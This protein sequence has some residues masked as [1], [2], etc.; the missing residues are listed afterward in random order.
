[1]EIKDFTRINPL[2]IT[3]H[4]S[5]IPLSILSYLMAIVTS[6]RRRTVRICSERGGRSDARVWAFRRNYVAKLHG[7][8][9]PRALIATSFT[10]WEIKRDQWK[11]SILGRWES[12][13]LTITST[14]IFSNGLI[15]FEGC[16]FARARSRRRPFARDIVFYNSLG[17]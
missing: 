6:W 3:R 5:D 16:T 1:M 11:S 13:R 8:I 14:P 9:D 15:I 2:S 10:K 7:T 12:G 17:L 4:R